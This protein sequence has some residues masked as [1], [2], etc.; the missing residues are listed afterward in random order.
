MEKAKK[1]KKPGFFARLKEGLSKTR[2]GLLGLIFGNSDEKIN[3]EF[4]E[5][6]EDALIELAEIIGGE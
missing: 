6:L 1:E 4:Y 2:G 5:E 3:D